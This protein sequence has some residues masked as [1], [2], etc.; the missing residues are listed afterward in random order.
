MFLGKNCR[1]IEKVNRL[2]EEY[3]DFIIKEFY[4][5]SK[6]DIYLAEISEK[7][8]LVKKNKIKEWKY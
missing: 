1:G 6:S 3:K 2:K 4:S 7:S 8:F 5:D